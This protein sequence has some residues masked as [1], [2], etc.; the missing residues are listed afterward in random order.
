MPR[1]A[2]G[3]AVGEAVGRRDEHRVALLGA[4]EHGRVAR[5]EELRGRVGAGD[6]AR[7]RAEPGEPRGVGHVDDEQA[8]GGEEPRGIRS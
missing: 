7:L 1:R 6:R 4:R 8:A 3:E 5:D 2:V